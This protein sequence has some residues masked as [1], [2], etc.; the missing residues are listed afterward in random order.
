M[1]RKTKEPPPKKTPA[2]IRADIHNYIANE[3]DTIAIKWK[4]LTEALSSEDRRR[5]EF[6]EQKIK[7][8]TRVLPTSIQKFA[9]VSQKNQH[10]T[11]KPVDLLEYL[12]KLKCSHS[13]CC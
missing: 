10:P 2:E 3:R 6:R 1:G 11:Q 9:S 12:V 13:E 5:D 7:D 8:D 4:A